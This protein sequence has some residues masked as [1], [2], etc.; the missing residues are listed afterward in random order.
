MKTML[1][2]AISLW[3][4]GLYGQKVTI[5]N[6]KPLLAA[7][8][9]RNLDSAINF[10][11]E[12]LGLQLTERKRFEDHHVEIA[13]LKTRQ[14]EFEL[15]KNDSSIDRNIVLK[16]KKAA[17]ITGFAKLN[18]KIKRIEKFYDFLKAEN[19]N[20]VVSL[21]KSARAKNHQTFIITDPEGNWVQ[22]TGK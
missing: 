22:F 21:R 20:I 5:K 11:S 17:E 2:L 14:F 10:Y 13:F 7:I 16:E 6:L 8:Q 4:Y 12:Y 18:F 9:V 3:G 15:V 19:V 1:A